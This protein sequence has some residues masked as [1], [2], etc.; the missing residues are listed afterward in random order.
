MKVNLQG[1]Y[2]KSDSYLRFI[3]K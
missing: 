3:D 2:I 1:I